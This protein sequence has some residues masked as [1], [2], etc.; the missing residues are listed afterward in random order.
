MLLAAIAAFLSVLALQL[1]AWKK[2]SRLA[3]SSDALFSVVWALQARLLEVE[4]EAE[5]GLT[6]PNLGIEL[7]CRNTTFQLT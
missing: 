7:E 1:Q 2:S 6:H 5:A 4:E 3:Q